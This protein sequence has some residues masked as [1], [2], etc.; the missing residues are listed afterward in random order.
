[1]RQI[2][3]TRPDDWH[4]HLRDGEVLRTTAAHISRYFGRAII[5]PNLVP[6][7][8]EPAHAKAYRDRIMSFAAMPTFMPLMT[9]YLTEQTTVDTVVAA[10]ESNIVA[11]FKYYPAG[12]TT[13]AE[14]GLRSLEGAY[15]LF[16]EMQ[17]RDVKLALHGEVNDNDVDIFD[18]ESVFIDKHLTALVNTFP[19]LKV[20]LE[21]ITTT[22]AV[23]FV[24]GAGKNLA[25]TV[26]AHHL[27][28]NRN[29]MLSGRIKPIYY[30]LP[31]LKRKKHQRALIAAATSGSPKFFLGTDSAP[32]PRHAKES[33]CG[34]AAG[35]YTAHAAIELYAEAFDK[36][37]AI[38]KLEC[39]ASFNGPDFYGMERNSD[40]I[41]LQEQSWSVPPSYAFGSDELIPIR[42][43]ERVLWRVLEDE[44]AS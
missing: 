28:Y 18:R 21:H 34:C 32:H 22:E 29:Q 8:T 37:D 2:V 39:F 30:C 16:E 42:G 5:M 23:D 44:D 41:V 25:A 20:V 11:A 43:G 1:M 9:L 26:T 4:V 13:N 10:S 19:D 35:S 40:T 14:A 27:L 6:P 38:D 17:K 31:V 12:A 36:A 33:A 15:P 3:I 7:I 24:T